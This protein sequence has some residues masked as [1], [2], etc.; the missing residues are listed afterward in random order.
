[1]RVRA[2]QGWILT[3]AAAVGWGLGQ[4]AWTYQE[5]LLHLDPADLFPSYPDLGYLLAV[6]LGVAGLLRLPGAPS[7]PG[8]VA[9]SALDGALI[10]GSLLFISWVLVLGPVYAQSAEDA[11][12]KVV[13]IAYPIGDIAMV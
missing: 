7:S 4:V 12:P 10:A 3:G 11:L 13:G 2:G 1:G 9:R 8:A 5:V 6:P